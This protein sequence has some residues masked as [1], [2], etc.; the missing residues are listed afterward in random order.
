MVIL[1]V[2]CAAACGAMVLGGAATVLQVTAVVAVPA[3]L[4]ATCGAALSVETGPVDPF[5]LEP[6]AATK[7]FVRSVGPGVLALAG[8][9]PVLAAGAAVDAGEPPAT[10]AAPAAVVVLLAVAA[11]GT[12][13]RRGT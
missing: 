13:L 7:L 10:G 8:V 11:A 2:V 6:F 5:L 3:V 1:G 4:A 9:L 12:W